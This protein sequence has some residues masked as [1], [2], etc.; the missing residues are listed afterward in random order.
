MESTLRKNK[1]DL[2]WKITSFN[3]EHSNC[4]WANENKMATT[5]LVAK[6]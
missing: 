5:T 1:D 2:A 4:V 6:R 3:D